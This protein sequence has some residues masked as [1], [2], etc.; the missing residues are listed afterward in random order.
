M[1]AEPSP[2]SRSRQRRRSPHK[3]CRHQMPERRGGP[4]RRLD[5]AHPPPGASPTAEEPEPAT[6]GSGS[7]LRRAAGGVATPV[8][9]SIVAPGACLGP[10]AAGLGSAA[11][12]A[13]PETVSTRLSRQRRSEPGVDSLSGL[14]LHARHHVA[15][16]CRCNHSATQMP[17]PRLASLG[18]VGKRAADFRCKWPQFL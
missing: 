4:V 11:W 12:H 13:E 6:P 17:G 18:R 10:R 5:G 1:V 8:L 7:S 16:T 3:L 14:L 9:A 2:A 15:G